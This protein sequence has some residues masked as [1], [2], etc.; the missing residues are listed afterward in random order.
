[1]NNGQGGVEP[2]IDPIY[3]SVLA[4]WIS[5]DPGRTADYSKDKYHIGVTKMQLNDKRYMFISGCATLKIFEISQNGITEIHQGAFPLWGNQMLRS[6]LEIHEDGDYII[7]AIPQMSEVQNGTAIDYYGG[8]DIISFLA[9]QPNWGLAWEDYEQK[10]LSSPNDDVA[11]IKGVEFSPNG[12]FL[13]VTRVLKRDGS[14]QFVHPSSVVPTTELI[15]FERNV[16]GLPKYDK[17]PFP[18]GS[19]QLNEEDFS[20]GMLEVDNSGSLILAGENRLGK[21]LDANNPNSNFHTPI[22]LACKIR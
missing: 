14:D 11:A 8:V 12:E 4:Q 21:L 15:Y 9:P 22:I 20:F 16:A 2:I 18:Y 17:I 13:Y 6:E 1:M 7:V 5:I 3:G 10:L 19:V